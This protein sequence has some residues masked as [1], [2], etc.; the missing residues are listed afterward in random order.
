MKRLAL[1]TEMKEKKQSG[2]NYI[3][4]FYREMT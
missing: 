2:S 4:M 3:I 1:M